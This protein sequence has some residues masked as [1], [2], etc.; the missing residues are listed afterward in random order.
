LKIEGT[1]MQPSG[2]A[3]MPQTAVAGSGGPWFARLLGK[4]V[5]DILPGALASL[6][7]TLLLTHYQ[8]NQVAHQAPAAEEATMASAETMARL[9]DEHA[10][11]MDFLK[12]RIAAE[13]SRNMAE[14]A[15]DARAV[16]DA[17]AAAEAAAEAEVKV[18]ASAMEPIVSK[19][20]PPRAKPH[21]VSP[22]A[23][24]EPLVI[25]QAIPQV[26]PDASVETP[27]GGRLADDPDSLLAKTLDIKDHVVAATRHVVSAI[28]DMFAS[29][30]E[31]LGGA[32]PGARQYSSAS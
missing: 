11:I 1:D 4:F 30:G 2:I 13:M 14:D 28:G 5:L 17:K 7:G 31:R 10:M 27:A 25:A 19:A 12:S 23:P 20:P 29:V 21:T 9:R 8:L 32:A 24:R 3:I 18:A 6:I 15:D 22:A 16:A 26:Q